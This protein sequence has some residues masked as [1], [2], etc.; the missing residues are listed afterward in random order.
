MLQLV[1]AALVLENFH[2]NK[3]LAGLCVTYLFPYHMII[4][5]SKVS[6]LKKHRV[7]WF[8]TQISYADIVSIG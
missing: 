4:L 3:L 2:K 5:Q 6:E 8:K 1:L 7:M